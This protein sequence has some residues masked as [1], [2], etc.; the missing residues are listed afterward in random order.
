MKLRRILTVLV[1]EFQE[2]FRD[3][4][5]RAIVFVAPLIQILIFG[6]AATYDIKEIPTA[7]L[8][9]DNSTLSRRL[10]NQLESSGYFKIQFHIQSPAQIDTLMA[11]GAVWCAV[12]IPT[13]FGKEIADGKQSALGVSIDAVNSNSAT[14]TAGYLSG[15]IA[16]LNDELIRERAASLSAAPVRMATVENRLRILYNP[17]L[18]SRN[19]NVPA[20]IVQILVVVTL[21]LTSMAIV[22]EKEFGTMEQ[23][24]VTPIRASELII[25]KALPY[26]FIGMVDITLICTVAVFYFKV[27]L[28]GSLTLLFATSLAFMMSTLAVGLLISIVSKTQQQA[29]MTSFFFMMPAIL[30]SGFAFPI[31]NMPA[32]IQYFTYLNPLRYF[33]VIIRDIFLKGAAT[34]QLV[35]QIVPLVALGL[36]ALALSAIWFRKRTR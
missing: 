15:V 35:D 5:M 7:V 28:L 22:K 24:A 12:D 29:M 31:E 33:V 16:R 34:T 10:V 25:G 4:K 9:R 30:L 13:D 1:K 3:A 36:G 8:D 21:L 17:D 26:A 32:P 18:E 23:L 14:I 6:Y 2:L 20:I 19:F 27:P 11:N